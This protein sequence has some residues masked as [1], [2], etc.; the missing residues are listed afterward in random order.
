M[1]RFPT[2]NSEYFVVGILKVLGGV[3][4][5]LLQLIYNAVTFVMSVPVGVAFLFHSRGKV[6]L[7]ERFGFW[8]PITVPVIWL[9]GASVGEVNGLL[10]L[11]PGLRAAHPDVKILLTATSVT[12]LARAEGAVEYNRLM[13]FD[14]YPWIWLATRNLS[15][16]KFIFS[17]TE[18]WPALLGYL[19]RRNVPCFM[20]NATITDFTYKK[21]LYI[22]W[23]IRP[24]LESLQGVAAASLHS[25]KRLET[26]GV[27]GSNMECTGNSKYDSTPSPI[28]PQDVA[29]SKQAFLGT[30]K[31]VI[32]LGSI[33]PGEEGYWF[34]VLHAHS[35]SI[36]WIIAPRHAE[37]FDYFA[38]A[39][40]SLQVPFTRWSSLPAGT[41]ADTSVVLLDTMGFLGRVYAIAN[42]AFI[43]GTLIPGI[44]GHNPLEAAGYGTPV[45]LGP[46]YRNVSA[47]V[48]EMRDCD[49]CFC[50]SSVHDIQGLVDQI[51]SKDPTVAAVG[52]RGAVIAERNRGATDRIHSFLTKRSA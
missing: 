48:D 8:Q 26:L 17:E 27:P 23:L 51:L 36:V 41:V 45:T 49:G 7:R 50:V 43:G 38:A 52:K 33:R 47:I 11:I 14:A 46:Y 20:V 29:E 10:Q 32:V 6:R 25:Q 31:P 18:I 3:I 13:P 16:K 5:S 35:D 15:V 24:V 37:K 1:K 30:L 9:H 4:V 12:G 40:Q 34:P 44:G 21:Y 19:Q 28:D 42:L 2:R 22:S 39:L